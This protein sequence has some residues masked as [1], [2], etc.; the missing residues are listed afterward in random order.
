MPKTRR[1][2]VSRGLVVLILLILVIGVLALSQ[3]VNFFAPAVTTVEHGPTRLSEHV[4]DPLSKRADEQVVTHRFSEDADKSRSSESRAMTKPVPRSPL[5]A[6][7]T[8]PAPYPAPYD[9]VQVEEQN[10]T[11]AEEGVFPSLEEQY[12]QEQY[13]HDVA[14]ME[15]I[16]Q[17]EF[18]PTAA[19]PNL[20]A[21]EVAA[22]EEEIRESILQEDSLQSLLE[23][24]QPE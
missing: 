6:S 23:D 10:P 16:L 3:L 11:F 17:R 15:E 20:T 19:A 21:E 1:T 12:A 24:L 7:T 14:A 2:Q 4:V 13:L 9:R 18:D 8:S 22:I 5:P